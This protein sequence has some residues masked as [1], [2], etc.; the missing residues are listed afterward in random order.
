V[1]E[2]EV[3]DL[4]GSRLGVSARWVLVVV[5]SGLVVVGVA[6]AAGALKRVSSDPFTNAS[7]QHATEVEPDTFAAGST[8]VAAFQ[9]GRFF[10]GGGSDIG[11]VRSTNGGSTWSVSGFLPGLTSTAGPYADPSSPF[12]SVSDASVAYDAKHGVWLISS[13]PLL[14]DFTVPTVFVSR[15]T[16]GGRT[17]APP[18]QIPAPPVKKVDLDKNWSVCDNTPTSPHYGTC[19]TEFDNAAENELLYMSAS[20]DGGLTWS[21]PIS[22]AGSPNGL[23]GQPLVQSDGTVVVPFWSENGRIAVFRST[24]GGQSWSEATVISTIAYHT[25]AGG[26]RDDPLPSAEIDGAGNVYVAWADCR[27]RKSCASNDIVFSTSPDG[28]NWSAP[29]RVPID[30]VSSSVDHFLPGLAV[31]P[32]TS[33]NTAHLALTYYFYPDSKCKADTCQL[34]VGFVSSP[35]GGAHWSAP[36]TLAGGMSLSDLAATSQ[37]PMVGD[38][39]ST[40]FNASGTATTVFPIGLPHTGTT[41]DEGMWV[42]S[43]PLPVATTTAA[44]QT[45]SSTGVQTLTGQTLGVAQPRR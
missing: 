5:A 35:D 34:E 28:L 43:T 4:M 9:A 24:D 15:S 25:T 19:Y 38:Y 40:S 11:Y 20:T 32:A 39:I 33:G 22:P 41:F 17:F 3:V 23:G 36:T 14:P 16:N 42:P 7:S 45:A 12:I 1:G 21:T 31:D 30:D 10:D 44:P 18:V 29:V 13:V 37:G 2:G 26:L 8:V 6:G 27:F